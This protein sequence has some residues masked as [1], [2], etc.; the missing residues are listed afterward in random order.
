MTTIRLHGLLS[1]KF[2]SIIKLYLGNLNHVI[3]AIDSIKQ[4]FRKK[5]NELSIEGFNYFIQKDPVDSNVIHVMPY[6]V[7]AGRVAMIVAIVIIMVVAIILT[8]GA[9]SAGVGAFAAAAGSTSAAAVTAG[10]TMITVAGISMTAVGAASAAMTLFSIAGSM[11][12]S[13]LTAKAP[14]AAASVGGAMGGAAMGSIAAGKSYVFSSANNAETQGSTIPLGY[15]K[16]KIGS[17]LINFS[18]KETPTNVL[19][20]DEFTKNEAYS[21]FS[22]YLAS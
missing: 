15:G 20:Q 22:N 5:I 1:K 6:V 16:M 14:E 10:A 18:I 21:V 7:G 9:A 3:S 4:D 13:M 11:A 17:K 12:Y 2:G 19:S 8:A